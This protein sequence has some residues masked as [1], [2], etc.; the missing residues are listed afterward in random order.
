MSNP[1]KCTTCGGTGIATV[2]EGPPW[3]RACNATGR[4]P[5]R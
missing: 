3:C 1:E 2:P 4:E 5:K